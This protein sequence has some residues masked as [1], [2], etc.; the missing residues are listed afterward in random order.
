MQVAARPNILFVC[1]DQQH[2]ALN[3]VNG[4]PEVTT[5]NMA[6]LAAMGT[7]FSHCYANSAVCVPSRASLFTGR[8]PHEVGAYDNA[9]PLR[10]GWPTF[11]TAAREQGYTNWATGKLD[12]YSDEGYGF[13]EYETS[14]GHER[15]PDITAYTRW[16]VIPR[17]DDMVNLGD[18][19]SGAP[20]KD[21]RVCD[22]TLAFLSSERTKGPAL[23]MVWCGFSAPHS[24]YQAPREFLDLYPPEKIEPPF[25]PDDWQSR[26]HPAMRQTRIQ[27]CCDVDIPVE[28][29]Q[30]DRAAYFAMITELD[31][32]LGRLLDMLEETGQL[33]STVVIFTSDHGDMMGEHGMYYKYTP[34]DAA[35]RVPL[36]IAGPGFAAGAVVDTPVSLVDVHATIMDLAGA[37][38]VE[39]CRGH[40]L[41]P[42]VAGDESNHPFVYIEHNTERLDTGQFSIVQGEWKYNYWVDYPAQ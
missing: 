17:P 31:G 14:H 12:F 30:H 15:S 41:L 25:F 32:N 4:H 39:N 23:W 42:L 5:P 24:P 6:R 20:H 19:D 8:W 33:E 3:S 2:W 1:S 38:S 27:R 40:S 35:A 21:A 9:A 29:H 11:G 26:E 28:R 36:I 34:Y 16:P 22:N 37:G 18:Y 7:N 13:E 10:P